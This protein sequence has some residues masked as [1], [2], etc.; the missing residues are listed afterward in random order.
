M[1]IEKD[2]YNFLLL[3]HSAASAVLRLRLL[4]PA[5]GGP[6]KVQLIAKQKFQLLLWRAFSGVLYW[7]LLLSR[8]T[9]NFELA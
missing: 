1:M 7:N 6:A 3:H 9:S 2:S 5:K 8:V 4:L